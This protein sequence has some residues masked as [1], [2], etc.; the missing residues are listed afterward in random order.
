[1]NYQFKTKVNMKNKTSIL[2]GTRHLFSALLV[3]VLFCGCNE[4]TAERKI[5]YTHQEGY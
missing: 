5:N 3:A 4:S 1:M 2:V